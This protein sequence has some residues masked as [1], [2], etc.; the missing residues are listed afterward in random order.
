MRRPEVISKTAQVLFFLWRARTKSPNF[1]SLGGGGTV[2]G[3]AFRGIFGGET[4]DLA[5]LVLSDVGIHASVFDGDKENGVVFLF[6]VF[7]FFLL[8]FLLLLGVHF[9]GIDLRFEMNLRNYVVVVVVLVDNRRC[10]NVEFE[11][12]LYVVTLDDIELQRVLADRRLF[13]FLHKIY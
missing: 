4:E 13:I 12:G 2:L 1:Y 7:L 11:L 8:H 9:R 3:D 10:D 5:E 6:L